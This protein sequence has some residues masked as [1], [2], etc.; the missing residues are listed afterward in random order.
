[1]RM[2]DGSSVDPYVAGNLARLAPI[3]I[4]FKLSQISGQSLLPARAVP[5]APISPEFSHPN[6]GE[7]SLPLLHF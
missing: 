6:Y 1:M 2:L 4:G 5:A 7:A 3:L